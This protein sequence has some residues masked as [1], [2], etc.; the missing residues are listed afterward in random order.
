MAL[1]FFSFGPCLVNF[2]GEDLGFAEDRVDIQVQ[3]FYDEIHTD[4]WGGLAGP[5]ADKQLLG[6]LAQISCLLTKFD[7]AACQRLTAFCA[8]AGTPDA[9]VIASANLGEFVYQDGMYAALLLKGTAAG[10]SS[11]QFSYAHVTGAVGFNASMRHRRYQ[12]TFQARMS[13]SCARQLYTE[14]AGTSCFDD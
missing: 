8:G 5:F 7:D 14:I 6:G 1:Q 10:S 12:L 13:T 11:L 2:D 3:P 4:S 9:G